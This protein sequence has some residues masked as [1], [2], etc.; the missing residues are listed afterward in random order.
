VR[1]SDVYPGIDVVY[2]GM[3]TSL[4]YDIVAAPGASRI[5]LA[6]EGGARSAI[7]AEGNI[8]ISTA[9]GE[10][11]VQRPRAY[12][13]ANDGSEIP[14]A[15]SFVAAKGTARPEYSISSRVMTV[16]VR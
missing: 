8:E 16:R 9:A 5:H 14:I 2:Y 6:I 1:V 3:P 13:R 12:Q 11:A 4:E 15:S 7:D 10:I